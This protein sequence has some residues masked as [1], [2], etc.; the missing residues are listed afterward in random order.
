MALLN[1]AAQRKGKK[2]K[3]EKKLIFWVSA[4]DLKPPLVFISA[5]CRLCKTPRRVIGEQSSRPAAVLS[6][7]AAASL[8]LGWNDTVSPLQR[9]PSFPN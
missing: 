2:G 3:E 1:Y 5:F 9:P 6:A 7:A 8:S 4:S